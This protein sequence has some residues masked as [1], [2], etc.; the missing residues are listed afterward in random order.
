MW[1][2]ASSVTA[3]NNSN[4]V[5]INS[6][7]SIANVKPGDALIIGSFN[8]VEILKAYASD[9]GSFIQLTQAW[10]NATQSQVPALVLPTRSALNEAI[11]AINGANK[12]VNDNYQAIL[13]W[14]T[15]TGEV[16][17]K[18][19]DNQ[20]VTVKTA[21]QLELDVKAVQPYP[22]AMRKAQ[23]QAHI[24]ETKRRYVA[25]GFIDRGRMVSISKVNGISGYNNAFNQPNSNRY[26]MGRSSSPIA[27]SSE[28]NHAVINLRGVICEL[29]GIGEDFNNTSRLCTIKLPQPE[30]GNRTYNIDTGSIVIHDT[31]LVAFASETNK[32]KV[33]TERYDLTC[34]EL[35]LRAVTP[36][37]PYVYYLGNIQSTASHIGSVPTVLDDVRP[38]SYFAQNIDDNDSH[39]RGVHWFTASESQ[40]AEIAGDKRNYIFFDDL[41]GKFYQWCKRVRTERGAGNGDW[42]NIDAIES[43]TSPL[44]FDGVGGFVRPQ[45]IN[46]K[47]IEKSKNEYYASTLSNSELLFS[48]PCKGLYQVRNHSDSDGTHIDGQCY[49]YVMRS[50][51]RLNAGGYHVGLNPFGSAAWW[52]DGFRHV[53]DKGLIAAQTTAD[54]FDLQ[55]NISGKPHI[56]SGTIGSGRSG[57][58]DARYC[59][60][61][62]EDGYGGLCRDVSYPA[63]PMNKELISKLAIN[64]LNGSN[65]GYEKLKFTKLYDVDTSGGVIGSESYPDLNLKTFFWSSKY[66]QMKPTES[67]FVVN[68]TTKEIFDSK[69]YPYLHVPPFADHVYWPT[70][71][72]TQPHIVVIRERETG[73]AVAGEFMHIDV[74]GLPDLIS[75]SIS[76]ANGF[77]GKFIPILPNGQERE[78]IF[79]RPVS[80]SLHSARVSLDSSDEWSY[81][82][83]LSAFDSVRNSRSYIGSMRSVYINAYY[84]KAKQA[85]PA[86][87]P[88]SVDFS[89]YVFVSSSYKDDS[90]R[91][92]C[93]SLIDKV[94]KSEITHQN[95]ISHALYAIK[96]M[97]LKN[98]LG[99]LVGS[100]SVLGTH[101]NID[102][103]P[104]T[105]QS[106]AIKVW[107]LY[108]EETG[109]AYIGFAYTE[110]KYSSDNWGDDSKIRITDLKSIMPDYNAQ[111]VQFGFSKTQPI[112]WL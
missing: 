81:I 32:N 97:A 70:S 78:F 42:N 95:E 17:F 86:E 37:D 14:Q 43:N 88:L 58:Y 20:E 16:T 68:M 26:W 55:T 111:D 90:G 30:I 28:S 60:A 18:A 13:D 101:E 82:T 93:Y 62:Y 98:G 79:T 48:E 33:V 6:N 50:V 89:D 19:F 65:L 15:K 29:F 57:R 7:E 104:P 10:I 67:Y 31:H 112:G 9:Q 107:P 76:L 100:N 64:S 12:L 23:M 85:V 91:N 110:L 35:Y 40:R 72:G 27:G 4:V 11:T 103:S 69:N 39:G 41:T 92:I 80:G 46:D 21:K 45:G 75:N 25:S 5:K 52:I 38:Q 109:L 108:F 96:N 71:W 49:L 59:D 1:F 106:A 47:P 24:D 94:C 51:C 83:D 54:C 2:T 87:F 8:P 66:I 44:S 63:T 3:T 36:E 34:V 56:N 74:A 84:T 77:Y 105:N 99:T 61:I 73:S 102:I 22:W 53:F